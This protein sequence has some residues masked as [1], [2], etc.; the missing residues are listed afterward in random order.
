MQTNVDSLRL[1]SKSFV[2]NGLPFPS[3]N[4][5]MFDERS[6]T[7]EDFIFTSFASSKVTEKEK[8]MKIEG[9]NTIKSGATF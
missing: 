6:V 8:N 9:K 1:T 5:P 4:H 7:E 2:N 3:G